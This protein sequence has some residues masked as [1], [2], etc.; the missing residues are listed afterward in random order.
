MSSLLSNQKPPLHIRSEQR[1]HLGGEEELQDSSL[2][3]ITC[4]LLNKLNNKLLNISQICFTGCALHYHFSVQCSVPI[5][6]SKQNKKILSLAKDKIYFP[7]KATFT[8]SAKKG[9]RKI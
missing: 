6:S 3:P 1:K 8:N 5:Q 7:N 2:T 9:K 4:D